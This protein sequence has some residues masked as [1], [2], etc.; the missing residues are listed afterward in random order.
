[1]GEL[2][3]LLPRAVSTILG[4]EP[5]IANAVRS[6]R[7]W[8]VLAVVVGLAFLLVS[9][10]LIRHRADVLVGSPSPNGAPDVV[11][12]LSLL[13]APVAATGADLEVGTDVPPGTVVLTFDDGPDRRYTEQILDV[14][15]RHQVKATFFMIGEQVAQLPDVAAEVARRGHEIGNHTQYH[16]EMGRLTPQQVRL[17]LDLARLAIIDATGIDTTLY[18]PPYSGR[19]DT[20][21]EAELARAATALDLGYT[22]VNTDISPP[23][24]DRSKSVEDL[25][26]S[27]LPAAG[28]GAMITLHDGGGNRE[29][30]IELLDP[31]IEQLRSAGY[32]FATVGDVVTAAT[33][34]APVAPADEWDR[35]HASV[36]GMV[37]WIS[38]GVERLA[39]VA[40]FTYLTLYA[41]RMAL[42]VA[43]G[44]RD[45]R[46]RRRAPAPKRFSGRVSVLVPAYNEAVGIADSLRSIE[47]SD[48]D[49]LEIIVIDDGSTDD[50]AEVV[51]RLDLPRTTLITKPNGGKPS[52]LN[53]GLR[54]ATGEVVVMVDGDTLLERETV[55]Q[56]V[57]PFWNPIVGAVSGNPKIG[58]Q[59]RFLPRLQASEYLLASSL[60]RRLL[61][62][63]RMVTTVPGAIGAWRTSAVREAGFVS[64]ATL[65]EDTDLTI[66]IGRGGWKIEYV[67]GARAWTEAPS[68]WKSF[69][70][71]RK[72]WTFGTLQAIWKHRGAC[73]DRGEGSRIGRFAMPYMLISGYALALLAPI[74]DVVLL[75]NVYLGQ[76]HLAAA[77]WLVIASI[78]A[79]AG[80]IAARLDGDPVRDALRV[81]LQQIL[82]RPV[83]QYV[84]LVS[85]RRAVM[86]EPQ[87]WGQQR[88][89][90]GLKLREVSRA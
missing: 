11:Y 23:D 19:I 27:S 87:A 4:D 84:A 56:V 49:D 54:R 18:R 43:F 44:L 26:E 58:N 59:N 57:A 82:Y 78:G 13:D 52:A 74:V 90:G 25:L 16:F 7:R 32:R 67:P 75:A 71:Q 89:V 33:G 29:R 38:S 9:G 61:A 72:R 36:L 1:M 5:W 22:V 69:V 50:T 21:N 46:R 41:L 35:I 76:W 70:A 55:S 45:H 73:L 48:Y 8:A 66:A 64:S 2:V 30:T 15:D 28:A 39:L 88:R 77:S 63:A 10:T 31:L 24:F 68:T 53:L 34:S 14:L 20:M 65:A 51:R 17:Q 62:P 37:L 85:L 6:L 81:P 47:A 42:L 12:N 60:E 86:G 80:V 83:M 40:A 79:I 3:R